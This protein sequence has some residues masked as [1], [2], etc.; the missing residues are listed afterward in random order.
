VLGE[1][2]DKQKPD[3]VYTDSSQIKN[4]L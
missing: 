1:E 3:I 4:R 2:V